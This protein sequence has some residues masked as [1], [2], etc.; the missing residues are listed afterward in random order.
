MNWHS[1]LIRQSATRPEGNGSEQGK[2]TIRNT[3]LES[4]NI[5]PRGSEYESL[6]PI[7]IRSER[8]MQQPWLTCIFPNRKLSIRGLPKGAIRTTTIA[9]GSR[10]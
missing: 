2:A 5:R 3:A 10:F 1:N 7:A 9:I 4:L 8:R 6:A